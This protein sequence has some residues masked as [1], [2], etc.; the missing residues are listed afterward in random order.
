MIKSMTG[1]GRGSVK[2]KAG[3]INVEI[4]SLNSRFID[5]KFL[6]FN[7]SPEA[8]DNFRRIISSNLKRG[9][10]KV[11]IEIDNIKDNQVITLNQNRFEKTINVL[12][13]IDK[14]YGL[15]LNLS[16]VINL[17]DM[18]S[19][20]DS[21]YGDNDKLI[22]AIKNALVQLNKMRT[23]EGKQLFKDLTARIKVMKK[24]LS[25]IKKLSDKMPKNKKRYL[26]EKIISIIDEGSIDQNRLMQ[27]VAYLI[28]R[29]DV[30]E[31][32]V[33]VDIHLDNFIQYLKY[34]DPVGKRLNFL[35][36]EINRE[37]NTIGSKSPIHDVTTKIVEMKNEIEK[38]RE[39]VQNI[40]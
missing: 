39:Q 20:V 17:N 29:A 27:E 11:Y 10:I 16:E 32:I 40:L 9:S 14:R 18:L 4:Q 15:R 38:V 3:E 36:Q 8:E 33:R 12:D 13:D 21:G 6:G 28:E 7:L 1:F 31:E 23:S 35:I 22:D 34:D 30:T 24:G 25:N 5:L 37:I 26:R 2:S 19:F